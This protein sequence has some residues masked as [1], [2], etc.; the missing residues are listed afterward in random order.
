MQLASNQLVSYHLDVAPVDDAFMGGKHFVTTMDML[1]HE[2]TNGNPLFR[3][4][5]KTPEQLLKM[6][7]N[8]NNRKNYRDGMGRTAWLR[9]DTIILLVEQH[10]FD[11]STP[12]G[13]ILYGLVQVCVDTSNTT[14]PYEMRPCTRFMVLQT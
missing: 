3:F 2:P 7:A 12:G 8:P 5:A 4:A 9:V 14:C 11:L 13:R 10:R 1:Q 6:V